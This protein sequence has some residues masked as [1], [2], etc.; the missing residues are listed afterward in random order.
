MIRTPRLATR[1]GSVS[2]VA[3]GLL[4]PCGTR[5]GG[6]RSFVSDV[7]HRAQVLPQRG[8]GSAKQNVA[9]RGPRT[10]GERQISPF[11]A[12][13]EEPARITPRA[14]YPSTGAHFR[15][16]IEPWRSPFSKSRLWTHTWC[17]TSA[18]GFSLRR[19][20]HST[21]TDAR[22]VGRHVGAMRPSLRR[23]RLFTAHGLRTGGRR[24]SALVSISFGSGCG[25]FLHG[26]QGDTPVG[27]GGG[28]EDWE[29]SP[30]DRDYQPDG[31]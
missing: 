1:P 19:N 30:P 6:R 8:T 15:P 28:G 10:I 24:S 27:A 13:Q 11:S 18:E 2:F 12:E 31:V 4:R 17:A 7:S 16:L 9:L 3:I 29:P 21:G 26:G 25:R 22:L 23:L 14:K 20:G 5:L